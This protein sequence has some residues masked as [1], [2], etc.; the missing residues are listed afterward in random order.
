MWLLWFELGAL[1]LLVPFLIWRCWQHARSYARAE[2]DLPPGHGFNSTPV[3]EK[4]NQ[5]R[6]D[7]GSLS[8]LRPRRTPAHDLIVETVR[9][10]LAK[11][12]YFRARTN[13]PEELGD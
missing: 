1:A 13:H 12:S 6:Q 5:L 11:L 3:Q 9:R 8:A 7:Y 4:L 10:S 2:R